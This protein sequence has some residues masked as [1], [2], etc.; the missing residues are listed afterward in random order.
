MT[1]GFH[2][3][4]SCPRCGGALLA[5]PGEV[6]DPDITWLDARCDYCCD[7]YR[8]TVTAVVVEAWPVDKV[9]PDARLHRARLGAAEGAVTLEP[10]W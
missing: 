3:D 2:F 6:H 1:T 4:A 8:L 10:T 7:L 5:E 9:D